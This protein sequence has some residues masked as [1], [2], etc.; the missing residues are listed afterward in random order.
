[1]CIRDSIARDHILNPVVPIPGLPTP[2]ARALGSA[3]MME[4]HYK[5]YSAEHKTAINFN[6]AN[7]TVVVAGRP[8]QL[9]LV[10]HEKADYFERDMYVPWLL[11]PL[12]GIMLDGY[13]ADTARAPPGPKHFCVIRH[14]Q[15]I[16][17]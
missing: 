15:V 14:F 12:Q 3:Q 10:S 4:A 17:S 16:V 7:H 1:M 9:L 8:V 5:T 6:P 11:R 2:P 13:S